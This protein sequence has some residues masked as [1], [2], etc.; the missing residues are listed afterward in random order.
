MKYVFPAHHFSNDYETFQNVLYLNL[1]LFNFGLGIME[2]AFLLV[3]FF[4]A[5]VESLLSPT[6]NVTTLRKAWSRKCTEN[7]L[8]YN[9]TNVF[10]ESEADAQWE[11]Y[12]EEYPLVNGSGVFSG[13]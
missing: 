7:H 3:T 13:A 10:L 9:M 11:F 5:A 6:G 4:V 2:V 1:T 8:L 12:C